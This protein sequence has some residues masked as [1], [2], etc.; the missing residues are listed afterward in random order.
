MGLIAGIPL[1]WGKKYRSNFNGTF[2]CKADKRKIQP[3]PAD[4]RVNPMVLRLHTPK[5]KKPG[6]GLG[7]HAPGKQQGN[8]L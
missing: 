5:K 8:W 3:V 2:A 4:G 6:A 1:K 7:D